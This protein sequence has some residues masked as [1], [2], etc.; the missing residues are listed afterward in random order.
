MP[1]EIAEHAA[2]LRDPRHLNEVQS[3][4]EGMRGVPGNVGCMRPAAEL[5]DSVTVTEFDD[6]AAWCV[7]EGGKR[8]PGEV[9]GER[10]GEE[11]PLLLREAR[12]RGAAVALPITYPDAVAGGVDGG[13]AW[14]LQLF[15]DAERAVHER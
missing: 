12:R 2:L 4:T 7:V 14:Q 6:L 9:G 15:R 1:Q 10:A 11:P 5:R 13:K 3:A 8:F